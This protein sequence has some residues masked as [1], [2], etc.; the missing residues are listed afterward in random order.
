MN[1]IIS[2]QTI[3]SHNGL[4][5]L[6]DLHRASGS[7]KKHQPALFMRN[8]EV[9]ALISEIEQEN[10]SSTD[11]Q[12]LNKAYET[13]VG[14]G[15]QQGTFVCKELVYRY[16][17]WISPKFSLMVIRAFDSL[18]Q[19]QF[20]PAIAEQRKTITVEQQSAIRLAV[21]KR[22]KSASVHYATIY[23]ALKKHF[24]IPRYTELL[25]CD[26]D[27]ALALIESIELNVPQIT[28]NP[29]QSY[30]TQKDVLTLAKVMD[31]ARQY[32]EFAEQIG[33]EQGRIQVATLYNRNTADDDDGFFVCY[34]PRYKD[35]IDNAMTLFRNIAQNSLLPAVA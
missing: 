34:R 19:S 18:T 32:A 14:K 15:K 13:V 22:C 8:T 29:N 28:H 2:N 5:S 7:E 16:A 27:E 21:A 11:L 30:L 12:T 4:F 31:Y 6:N 20:I 10:S 23:E 3:S 33:N 25:A 9:Q 26:F 35:D 24:D 1:L 17:M